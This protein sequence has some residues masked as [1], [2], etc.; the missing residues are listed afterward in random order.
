MT[1]G[2]DACNTPIQ[3]VTHLK[4]DQET[5]TYHGLLPMC[6]WHAVSVVEIRRELV[7]NQQEMTLNFRGYP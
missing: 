4:V 1:S 7:V 3:V 2:L 5:A 6:R